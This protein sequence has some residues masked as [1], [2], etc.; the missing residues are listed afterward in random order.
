MST[1][2]Q[3]IIQYLETVAPPCYQADYDNAGLQV[4][5][6]KAPVKGVLLALDA[7]EAVLEEAV[8][9][10][11]NLIIVHHPLLFRPIK[12]VTSDQPITRAIIYAIQHQLH[13]YAIHTN[14]DHIA[15]GINKMLGET[16]G[17]TQL[18]ILAPL[19][20]THHLLT[21]FLP[22]SSLDKVRKALF[23]AG[24]ENG[25]LYPPY[26]FTSTGKGTFEPTIEAIP[27]TD[28][29]K[30]VEEICLRTVVAAHNKDKVIST[31]LQTHPYEKPVYHTQPITQH[32]SNLGTGMIG[33]LE[34]A[35]SPSAFLDHVKEKLS[36]S[37]IRYTQPTKEK[38]QRVAI[39]GGSGSTFLPY[40]CRAKA[41][42]FITAD[43]K[44]HQFFEAEKKLMLVDIGHYES[45]IGF[46][47]LIYK[48]LSKKFDNIALQ[49]CTTYTN[50]IRYQ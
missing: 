25:D 37:Q 4:G 38:I 15:T 40:A 34:K 49:K 43:T 33:T 6:P 39:C 20:D 41:H 5:D 8:E 36:L 50:P 19:P 1:T 32:Q 3:N 12:R 46:T 14:L 11:C 31:L 23:Q 7:T 21:T 18:R 17:L 45:E 48:L 13:I 27:H 35:L 24:A 28:Q 22:A 29:R 16:L 30:E 44:Y 26:S 10:G 42:A 9:K 47:T 2:V